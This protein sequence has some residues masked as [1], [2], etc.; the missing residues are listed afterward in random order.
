MQDPRELETGPQSLT[1]WN[2][3]LQKYP[4]QP[5]ELQYVNWN[6]W[7]PVIQDKK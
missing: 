1:G 4:V 2:Q 5:S 7:K 6:F 3:L